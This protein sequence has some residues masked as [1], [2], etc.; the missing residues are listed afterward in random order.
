MTV[1]TRVRP[2]S[3]TIT[4]LD[5]DGNTVSGPHDVSNAVAADGYRLSFPQ[6]N[7]R[8]PNGWLAMR[9]RLTLKADLGGLAGLNLDPRSST[10]SPSGAALLAQ[11]NQVD[12]QIAQIDRTTMGAVCP[13]LFILKIERP[14]NYPDRVVELSLGDETLLDGLTPEG[15]ES[16]FEVGTTTNRRTIINR[17]LAAAGITSTADPLSR[18]SLTAPPQKLSRDN[19]ASEAGKIAAT[20]GALGPWIDSTGA[21]RLTDID[22]DQSAPVLFLTVGEGGDEAGPDGWLLESNDERPPAKLIVTA[23][24]VVPV[25]IDNPYNESRTVPGDGFTAESITEEKSWDF[26]T[27]PQFTHEIDTRRAEKLIRPID[28]TEVDGVVTAEANNTTTS[29]R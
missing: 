22:L 20:A 6:A 10:G 25:E 3:I 28:Y 14:L 15:D 16:G 19:W 24:A 27:T 4:I 26:G 21:T 12:I 7:L 29:L 9:G 23:S 1:D 8:E 5:A 17:Y 11:G 2:T 13:P 18:Y